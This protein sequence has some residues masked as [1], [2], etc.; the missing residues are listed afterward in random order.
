[1][2]AK[3]IIAD[4]YVSTFLPFSG[5]PRIESTGKVTMKTSENYREMMASPDEHFYISWGVPVQGVRNAVIE[6]GFF[7]DSAHCDFNG[8]YED[9]SLNRPEARSIVESF[10]A[11]ISVRQL[12][13]D[14]K[15][16]TKMRQPVT[17]K[18][19][20]TGVVIAGQYH[21]DRSIK[22][23]GSTEDYHRFIEEACR[24]Y[25]K[26]ALLKIHPVLFG[27]AQERELL[28]GIAQRYGCEV[29]FF[30]LD[31]VNKAEFVIT[32]N[33]TCTIDCL[34]RGKHVV[35]YA[36]GYF[37]KVGVAQY[38]DRRMPDDI[39]P[40][41]PAYVG[42]FL[43]FVVWRYCFNTRSHER[44]LAK[45]LEAFSQS[46]ELFPLPPELSYGAYVTSDL[47]K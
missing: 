16:R 35:T 18:L 27:N 44:Y 26:R 30:D 7:W 39:V 5:F 9:C 29:G 21:N 12:F 6:T 33:S 34:L 22:R 38:S 31:I 3:R 14:G 4:G 32:Y 46:D 15:L 28:Y 13:A 45:I 17:G 11:P 8:L 1:V 2:S 24:H 43:D 20:W 10:N 19:E 23:V 40:A 41:D 42:K 36:P 37:W 25:G 47:S